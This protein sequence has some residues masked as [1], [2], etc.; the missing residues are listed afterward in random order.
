MITDALSKL[1]LEGK[2]E[3]KNLPCGYSAFINLLVPDGKKIVV[4]GFTFQLGEGGNIHRDLFFTFQSSKKKET[5]VLK[6][7]LAELLKIDT[8]LLFTDDIRIRGSQVTNFSTTDFSALPPE[9][10]EPQP[11]TGYGIGGL[12]VDRGFTLNAGSGFYNPGSEKYDRTGSAL[13]RNDYFPDI[14]ANSSLPGSTTPSDGFTLNI[15]F[16]IIHEPYTSQLN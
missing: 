8:F 15:E 10:R 16:V 2:A 14:D 5:F 7:L 13:S 6:P 9:S 4:T 11:P 1:I 3:C 12:T